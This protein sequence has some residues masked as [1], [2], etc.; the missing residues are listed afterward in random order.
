MFDVF[1]TNNGLSRRING[2][3]TKN[4][5]NGSI[6]QGVGEIDSFAFSIYPN[7]EGYNDI[8]SRQTLITAVNETTKRT[9]FDG[10]ILL[11]VE[12]MDASGKL[13]K[14]VTAESCL[15]YL[16]DS[17]QPYTAEANYLLNDF[18]D[19]V[20]SN[21]NAQ[22]EAYKRIYRGNVDVVTNS[23]GT[24]YK[25]LNYQTTFNI[26]KEKLVNE[27]GGE[28]SIRRVS[29]VLY[30]DYLKEGGTTRATTI[31]LG[32][33][34]QSLSRE[35]NPLSV[36]T[37]VIPLGAK[38][39]VT[40]T[41]DEGN[42]TERETEE[43]L[44]VKGYN[45]L[46]VNYID[47]EEKKAAYGIVC[48]TL[49]FPDVTTQSNLY[50]KAFD[51][52][53]NNNLI[54][55]KHTLTALDLKEIGL[56]ID[57][58]YCGDS[59]PVENPLMNVGETMRIIKKTIDINAAYKSA[60][61]IGD[62]TTT[63]TQITNQNNNRFD[64]ELGGVREEITDIYDR[65]EFIQS[66]TETTSANMWKDA[67][68][69]VQEAMKDVVTTTNLAEYKQELETM[70]STS[71]AGVTTE[72]TNKLTEIHNNIDGTISSK[73]K[74]LYS[75]I[76]EYMDANGLPVIELGSEQSN[77]ICRIT[78]EKIAFLQNGIEVAYISDDKLFITEAEILTSIIIGNF[79]F[80]PRANGNLSFVKVR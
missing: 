53:K 38:I 10:R 72:F 58:F 12:K 27:F 1:I 5:I 37:R 39:K 16:Q 56:E 32:R 74:E 78:S 29:G 17:V 7:N 48:G 43:R 15:G 18:I 67:E 24:V 49:D 64:V 30:L 61:T 52:L 40:E 33:N 14:D 13:Y 26:L 44:T 70:V 8:Q 75:Y 79:A 62:K 68:K 19:L 4:R 6:T 35:I 11:A 45:G 41:D 57:G 73:F 28:L 9:E 47:D 69:L 76:R 66:V 80:V 71:A 55:K 3:L 65:V 36:I 21:H 31:K 2:S 20:L 60:I 46:T 54:L 63:L 51:W 77:L 42:T 59:Y 34:L 25:N 22:V 23:E 50:N